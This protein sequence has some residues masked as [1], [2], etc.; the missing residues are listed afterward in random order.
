MGSRDPNPS[1]VT[2]VAALAPPPRL[3]SRA[4]TFR[5]IRQ[6][7]SVMLHLSHITQNVFN[8]ATVQHRARLCN[9][10]RMCSSRGRGKSLGM[11]P[12]IYAKLSTSLTSRDV[13]RGGAE[14]ADRD[15]GENEN[16][17]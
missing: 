14:P 9:P 6:V 16:R 11:H 17:C 8:E 12:G 13:R 15:Y 4:V 2:T 1:K 7:Y 3:T 10:C 5:L